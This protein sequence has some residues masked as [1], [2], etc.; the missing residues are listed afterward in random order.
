MKA[1][2]V[3]D[4]FTSRRLIQSILSGYGTCDIAINGIEAIEAFKAAWDEKA[5]YNLICMDIMMPIM[6]GHEA[7]SKIKNLEQEKGIPTEKEVKV[8]ITTALGDPKNV[9]QALYREGAVTYL[10]KPIGKQRLLDELR[11]LKL[12]KY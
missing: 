1:L 5:P 6:D 9:L 10:V 3:E 11:K 12:I 4:D 7:L 8:I 2:I